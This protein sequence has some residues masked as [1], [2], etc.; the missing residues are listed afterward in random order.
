MRAGDAER[1]GA[2]RTACAGGSGRG[3]GGGAPCLRGR[4]GAAGRTIRIG[5]VATSTIAASTPLLAGRTA[6]GT[7]VIGG[8]CGAGRRDDRAGARTAVAAAR[9]DGWWS[10]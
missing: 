5:V 9:A 4:G 3:G 6:T 8:A 7:A 2:A 10:A 1:C